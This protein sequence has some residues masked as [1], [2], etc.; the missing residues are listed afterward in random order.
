MQHIK[1]FEQFLN[2]KDG[3]G[4]DFFVKEKDGKV[5]KYFFKIDGE[6][7]AKGFIVSIGKLSRETSIDDAENSYG[8]ISV[9][10]IKVS[11]MDDYLVNETDYKSRENDEFRLTKSEFMRFYN[12]V[13]ECIKDYLQSN[14]KVSKF[15]DEILLNLEMGRDDYMDKCDVLMDEWSY[16]KWSIQEGPDK[17][18][19][20]YTRRDHD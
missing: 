11:I 4:R 3:Y 13:G 8:V 10:P 16:N 17:R 19:L 2:E 5:S 12:I 1:L 7:Q 20:V 14:P 18:T 6:D 9:E 15:Y